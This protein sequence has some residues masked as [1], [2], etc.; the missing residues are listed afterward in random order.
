M[1]EYKTPPLAFNGNKKNMLKLYREALEDMRCYITKETIFYDVFGGS[2]FLAHET[3]RLF[4]ENEEDK[5]T[6]L[7]EFIMA[8]YNKN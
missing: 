3:K 2:G 5:F 6:K 4:R 1:L 8:K 7:E